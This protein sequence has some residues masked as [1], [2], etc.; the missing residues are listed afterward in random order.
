MK[1]SIKHAPIGKVA[2][3]FDFASLT[4]N[5]LGVDIAPLD[6]VGHI[7]SGLPFS[8]AQYVDG[9]RKAKNF[10]ASDIIALDIDSGAD[11]QTP[12]T[13]AEYQSLLNDPFIQ[14]HAFAIIQSFSFQPHAY[15]CRVLFHLNRTITDA[16]DYKK[17]VTLV[18]SQIPFAANF[19]LNPIE[20]ET[21]RN[22]RNAL[23]QNSVAPL[24]A[25][26][27]NQRYSKENKNSRIYQNLKLRCYI[28]RGAAQFRATNCH[29]AFDRCVRKRNLLQLLSVSQKPHLHK[30][31]GEPNEALH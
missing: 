25:A 24:V 21:R 22:T 9:Y 23:S 27:L 26:S 17:L 29:Y 12:L 4:R 20:V 7:R 30:P 6:L 11:H 19:I 13:E 28:Y 8:V 5:W 2:K 15:K 31:L 18:M 3:D 16:A 10:I 1:L 14:Q